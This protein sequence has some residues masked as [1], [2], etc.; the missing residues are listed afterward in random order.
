[1]GVEAAERYYESLGRT[2]ERAAYIKARVCA[3][4]QIAGEAFLK[5][6]RPFV[7]RKHLDFAA[8]QDAHAMRLGY[9]EKIGQSRITSISGHNVKLGLGGIREIEFFTQTQQLIAGDV[10]PIC[11]CGD[12]GRF[13]TTG[14]QGMDH[15]R[16]SGWFVPLLPRSSEI[17]TPVADGE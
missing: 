9:R 6:M 10:I 2:W 12:E 1:M 8:I 15:I 11:G 5:S 4:D 3:G 17:G 13:A 7:W 16:F 14:H